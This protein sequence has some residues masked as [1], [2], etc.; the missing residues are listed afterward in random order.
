MSAHPSTA[1]R[2]GL[3]LGLAAG[4]VVIAVLV[5]ASE[6][7]GGPGGAAGDGAAAADA[8]LGVRPAAEPSVRDVDRIDIVAPTT[9]PAYPAAAEQRTEEGALA[10][11]RFWWDTL[12]Y[13][14]ATNDDELLAG[15]TSGSC[16]QCNAW[17]VIAGRHADQGATM[18]GGLTFPVNLAV[19]PVEESQPVLFRATFVSTEATVTQADGSAVRYPR[20]VSEGTFT[21]RWS[22]ESSR[23]LMIDVSLTQAPQ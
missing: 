16:A 4:A 19:G 23:W 2:L 12:N 13:S 20:L 9:V 3:A 11:Q 14:L 1:S 10:F 7:A 15:H 17:L 21:V 8:T 5:V 6:A 18:T 22:E